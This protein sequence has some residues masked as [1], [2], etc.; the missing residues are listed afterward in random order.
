MAAHS[1]EESCVDSRNY[2]PNMPQTPAA[3]RNE[4]PL[5]P[6]SCYR[7]DDRFRAAAARMIVLNAFSSI[8][9]PSWRSM[10]RR[11][12]PSRLELNRPDGSSSDAPLGNVNL[13]AFLYASPVQMFPPCDQTG[14][15]HFHSSTTSG[16]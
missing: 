13:T 8:L 1:G 16:T 2:R 14:T 3:Y 7:A 11:V 12:L 15:A 5:F 4:R 10:A 9:S 6:G